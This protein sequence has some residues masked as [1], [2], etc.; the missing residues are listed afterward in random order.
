MLDLCDL[1]HRPVHSNKLA[2]KRLLPENCLVDATRLAA[3]IVI[4]GAYDDAGVIRTIAMQPNEIAPVQRQN[5]AFL[6]DRESQDILVGDCTACV[7]CLSDSQR[8]VAE[9]T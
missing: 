5:G 3:G 7:A 1:F 6:P 4:L 9:R 8:V 2:G